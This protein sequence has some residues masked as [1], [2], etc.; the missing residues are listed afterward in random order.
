[1]P[2]PQSSKLLRTQAPGNTDT[3]VS[4]YLTAPTLGLKGLSRERS[5]PEKAAHRTLYYSAC[6]FHQGG[7]TVFTL[8]GKTLKCKLFRLM[9]P[10][11]PG[12]SFW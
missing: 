3:S 10:S 4:L 11:G 7:E 12:N 6:V 9:A 5:F 2:T 1:M 8:L